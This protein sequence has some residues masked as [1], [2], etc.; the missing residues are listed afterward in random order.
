MSILEYDI[1]DDGKE[2]VFSAQPAEKASELWLAPLDRSSPP[3]MIASTGERWPRFGSDGQVLFQFTDEKAN[4]IGRMQRDGSA[5]SK[6]VPYAINSFRAVSPDR[7]WVAAG[8]PFV[9]GMAVM[10]IPTESGSSRRICGDCLVAWA[11]DGKFLYVG[12]FPTLRSGLGKTLA[13]PIPA[14]E[15]LPN[16]PASGIRG[17]EDAAAFAGARVLDGLGISPG[18]DPSRYAYVKTSVHRNLYRIPLE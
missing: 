9:E 13:I 6:V 10:A 4:Y 3:Q 11:P 12:I 5:R 17:A 14:G 18:P 16:L 1:S 8:V 2:V 15:T 7:R